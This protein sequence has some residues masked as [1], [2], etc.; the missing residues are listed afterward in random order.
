M[1]GHNVIGFDLP[2]L[3]SNAR[4]V[5]YEFNNDAA[6]TLIMARNNLGGSKN[7]LSDVC[8][9]LGIPLIGAHR[10]I[11]DAEATAKCFL[12]LIK[13]EKQ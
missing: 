4:K 7:K 9:K 11:N 2:M 10:A 6:D 1:V 13:M 3:N 12:K 5:K 8:L